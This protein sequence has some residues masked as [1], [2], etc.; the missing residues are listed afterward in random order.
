MGG[1]FKDLGQS[2]KKSADSGYK[3]GLRKGLADAINAINNPL[4][5]QDVDRLLKLQENNI[6]QI[7]NM[8][9]THD[10]TANFAGNTINVKVKDHQAGKYNNDPL[11]AQNI[12]SHIKTL[13]S[14]YTKHIVNTYNEDKKLLF[15]FPDWTYADWINERSMWQRSISSFM[16]ERGW[17]Y[18]KIFFDFNT[19]HGLLG[20]L[21][22]NDN[23]I[24]G[25][26]NTALKFLWTAQ[27][28]YGHENLKQRIVALKKFGSILSNIQNNTPWFFK[29][30]KGLDKISSPTKD[31]TKDNSFTIN[32]S[33]ESVDMRVSTMLDLYRFAAF[34]DILNKEIIPENLRKFDVTVL[35]FNTP[36]KKYHTS[37]KTKSKSFNY[38]GIINSSGSGGYFENLMTYKMYTFKNCEIDLESYNLSQPSELNNEEPINFKPAIQIKYDRL[39]TH[40]SN[41][42]I[43]MLFGPDGIYYNQYTNNTINEALN[44]YNINKLESVV[45]QENR[46]H[47]LRKALNNMWFNPSNTQYKELIDASEM[48]SHQLIH[49]TNI[50]PT[51]LNTAN[52]KKSAINFL[53]DALKLGTYS[54]PYITGRWGNMY[55]DSGE[56]FGPG[57]DYFTEK[58]KLLK[59]GELN[60]SSSPYTKQNTYEYQES[61]LS[62]LKSKGRNNTNY[63]WT[64]P[65]KPAFVTIPHKHEVGKQHNNIVTGDFE[66]MDEYYNDLINNTFGKNLL[67]DFSPKKWNNSSIIV[68]KYEYNNEDGK[69]IGPLTP[70]I[71]HK[72]EVGKQH[73]NMDNGYSESMDEYYNDL[74]NNTFGPNLLGDF[75]PKKWNTSSIIVKKYEYNNKDGKHI[76]PLTPAIPHKHEVDKQHNNMVDGY[77]ESMDEYYNGLINNISSPYVN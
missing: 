69:H 11:E 68:K 33:E 42:F 40:N 46:Y 36:I 55:N 23:D 43:G 18:F 2:L 31:F 75:S 67:G 58:L 1:F 9:D 73:N 15:K 48:L 56:G 53:Y 17:F 62:K 47:Q 61:L 34:D 74:I 50:D 6:K 54:N 25:G 77:S 24:Y 26:V 37:F 57:T 3:K 59:N 65:D 8:L 10:G 27:D 39:Y 4:Y 30:I 29:S 60:N 5:Y 66:S 21:L 76:G 49:H 64:Y 44:L 63:F 38:K 22:N 52:L 70:A 20:G 16:S 13:T 28:Y 12:R 32:C 41:E 51:K 35:V 7:D 14:Q 71:P 45:S 72:H 19:E